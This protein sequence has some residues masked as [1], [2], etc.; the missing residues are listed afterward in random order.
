VLDEYKDKPPVGPRYD[1]TY[2]L[3][4]RGWFHRYLHLKSFDPAVKLGERV[5]MG[6]KLGTL[7]KEGDSGGWAHLH[8]EIL[9]LQPSGKWGAVEGYAFLWEAYVRES[10]AELIAVARPHHAVLIGE[11]VT[12]DASR[13][14]SRDGKIARYEWTFTDGGQASGVQVEKT[15]SKPGRYSEV[16]KI[17]NVWPTAGV[18]SGQPVT[19]KVRTFDT[20]DGQ[21]TWNFGDGS[22]EVTTRSPGKAAALAPDGYAETTHTFRKAGDYLVR[23][24][25]SDAHGQ[26]AVARFHV[27]IDPAP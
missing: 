26:K 21:E 15:Y 17:T 8:Y 10:R 6:Q 2:I 13:S 16:L 27:R 3:D 23:V 22:P 25:R 11:K 1:R 24:E 9:G 5:K 4:N 7:G 12:L 20:P 18:K 19:F 14:W